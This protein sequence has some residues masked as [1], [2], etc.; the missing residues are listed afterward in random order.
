MRERVQLIRVRHPYLG[1]Y[2]ADIIPSQRDDEHTIDS[3]HSHSEVPPALNL[4]ADYIAYLPIPAESTPF[5]AGERVV[6]RWGDE[7][8]QRGRGVI[9][10]VGSEAQEGGDQ[11]WQTAKLLITLHERESDLR[12]YPR[13]LTELQVV[14]TPMEMIA[15][16]ESWLSQS[17]PIEAF[18][19]DERFFKPLNS[20]V[21]FSVSGVSFKAKQ[22]QDISRLMLCA[23]NIDAHADEALRCLAKV[24]RSERDEYEEES[25]DIVLNFITPPPE[26]SNAMSQLTLKLQRLET[27]LPDPSLIDPI[28][29]LSAINLEDL[30]EDPDEVNTADFNLDDLNVSSIDE[31]QLE[32]LTQQ[33]L[34]FIASDAPPPLSPS[35]PPLSHPDSSD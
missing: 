10:R 13:M 25:F 8:D 26:L 12:H 20:L 29:A 15:D 19:Q 21:N 18:E 16:P 34:S 32:E 30:E 28:S 6:L 7:H 4:N 9:A 14:Y 33:A 3:S 2:E 17:G 11:A 1:P 35:N 31:N 5:E 27:D 24:V 23:L 22:A